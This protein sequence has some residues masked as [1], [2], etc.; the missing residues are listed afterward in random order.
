MHGLPDLKID[1]VQFS[2]SNYF[3][4]NG[5]EVGDKR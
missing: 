3:Q 4:N 1:T 2:S 5:G